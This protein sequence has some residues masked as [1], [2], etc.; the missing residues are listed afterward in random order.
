MDSEENK[1]VGSQQSWSK[2]GTI[3]DSQ[4]KEVSIPWPHHKETRELLGERDNAKNNKRCTQARKTT[5][6][7]GGQRQ[8]LDR[9]HGRVNQNGR[10]QR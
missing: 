5:H 10:V 7:L 8:D 9:T 1:L 4:I 3:K 2:E 6:S